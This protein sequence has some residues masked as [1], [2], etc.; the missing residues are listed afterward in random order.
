[1]RILP[2]VGGKGYNL[3]HLHL[4]FMT[5]FLESF[6]LFTAHAALSSKVRFL[7][8]NFLNV[9]DLWEKVLH[10]TSLSEK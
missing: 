5:L 4:L 9:E 2:G 3:F 8:C 6:L 7:K 1:M 10:T